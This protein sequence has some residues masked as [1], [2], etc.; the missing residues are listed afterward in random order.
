MSG[1][2]VY[3]LCLEGALTIREADRLRGHLMAALEAHPAVE[4]HCDGATETD[5][6]FVQ[7]LLAAQRTAQR[8]G[9]VFSLS[10]SPAG[11]LWAV[12]V[13]GGFLTADG[14]PCGDG[15]SFW[16]MRTNEP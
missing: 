3:R 5:L 9:R 12:L 4:V 2:G 1:T 6:A 16:T 7:L 11:A 15:D 10:L 14:S 8:A 13:R